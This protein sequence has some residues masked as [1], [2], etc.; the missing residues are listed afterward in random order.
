MS[1]KDNTKII[2]YINQQISQT[3]SFIQSQ[4]TEITGE[5]KPQRDLFSNLQSYIENFI[6][7]K[8]ENRWFVL[9]GLRGTGKTTLLAQ[10]YEA[11]K[12]KEAYRLFLMVDQITK[13]LDLSLY[14]VLN[15][16]SDIL[17]RSFEDLDKPLLLFLD[18]VQTEEKWGI[19]LKNLY[20]RSRKVF[21]IATG[22]AALVLNTNAD[23]ARRAIYED[24]SPLHFNEY[25]RLK[26]LETPTDGKNWQNIFFN[27][28]S[29]KELYHD[30]KTISRQLQHN[31]YGITKNEIINFLCYG[32][33][34]FMLKTKNETLI[35]SQVGKIVERIIA[36][37]IAETSTFSNEILS[38]I[39]HLLYMLADSDTK[40]VV[41]LAADLD[42]S[43]PT[44]M[45]ILDALEKTEVLQKIYPY[46]SH[47]SQ[48][49]KPFKYLFFASTFRAMYFNLRSSIKSNDLYLGKLLE[50]VVGMYLNCYLKAKLN[51][52]INYDSAKNGADFILSFGKERIIIETGLGKKNTGQ[53]INTAKKIKAKYGILISA[54]GLE[55]I[56]EHNI[57]KIPLE[58]FLQL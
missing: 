29:S 25:L 11:N 41:K 17:N 20:D 52:A 51:A 33:L 8:S 23:V 5:Q 50:D 26:K 13:I 49:N 46:G 15:S 47:T 9:T 37:D 32:S 19:V 12:N 14:D 57:V 43:K 56:P 7:N 58:F 35:Y 4:I 18:E 31:L 21:I 2:E 10:L 55:H 6:S 36:N 38:K 27:S 24:L 34:P 39:Q 3:E 40:S 48:I 53:I 22:S 28:K 1:L 54:N 42:I 30:T 45:E 44:L 16:Y